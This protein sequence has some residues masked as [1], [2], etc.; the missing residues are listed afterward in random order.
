MEP[1][2]P[3]C[4]VVWHLLVMMILVN[5][6]LENDPKTATP[7][8]NIRNLVIQEL[9]TSALRLALDNRNGNI[10][11]GGANR[12]YRLSNDDLSIIDEV[13]TGPVNDSR[14]CRPYPEQCE[15]ERNLAYNYNQILLINYVS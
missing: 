15:F 1:T 3:Y 4:L 5:T 12:I 2:H 9:N 6:Q 14:L 7:G 13:Q 11:V 8:R 10:L